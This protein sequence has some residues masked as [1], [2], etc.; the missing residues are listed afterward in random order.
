VADAKTADDKT[1]DTEADAKATVDINIDAFAIAA[2]AAKFVTGT[3]IVCVVEDDTAIDG[4]VDAKTASDKAVD[5]PADTRATDD[6][7]G[8]GTAIAVLIAKAADYKAG[9]R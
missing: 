1:T 9:V 7:T 8:A 3:E 5:A 2:L 6:K 4:L